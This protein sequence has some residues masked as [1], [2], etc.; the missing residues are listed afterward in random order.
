[1]NVFTSDILNAGDLMKNNYFQVILEPPSNSPVYSL[2]ES[3][4]GSTEGFYIRAK[5]VDLPSK[6]F[7]T[8]ETNYMGS[9][10]VMPGKVTMDG[11]TSITF[12]EFQDM[13]ISRFI[14][15]WMNLIYNGGYADDVSVANGALTGGAISNSLLSYSC[16][17]KIT[18]Y[19]STKK[20]KLPY[21][22]RLM[23][24]FPSEMATAGLDHNGGDKVT[25]QV[26]FKYST[27]EMIN[28]T[29]N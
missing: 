29:D 18:I 11:Q 13:K 25:R 3:I 19:D 16:P 5:T 28:A 15:E 22:Y 4:L 12:D 24:C 8:L 27:W 10:L 9:K 20:N 1:M 21:E 23:F 14:H 26:T 17:I 6:S 2:M 7:D